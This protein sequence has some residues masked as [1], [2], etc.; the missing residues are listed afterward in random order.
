MVP[1]LMQRRLLDSEV[2]QLRL[3][4]RRPSAVRLRSG[5]VRFLPVCA[6]LLPWLPGAASGCAGT[7]WRWWDQTRP[8]VLSHGQLHWLQTDSRKR[9]HTIQ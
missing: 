7:R 2:S 9:G 1:E 5:S 3:L 8:K 6:S 4:A